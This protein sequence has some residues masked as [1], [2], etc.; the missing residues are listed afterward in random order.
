SS[1]PRAWSSRV[2][3]SACRSA[4]SD[5][6][7]SRSTGMRAP[8]A[9]PPGPTGRS[10]CD[11]RE[12]SM[13][14]QPLIAVRDVQASSQWYQRLLRCRSA[15]GGHEYEQLVEPGGACGNGVLLWFQVDDFDAAVSRAHALPAEVLDGPRVNPNA[16]HREIWVRDLDGYVVVLASRYGDVCPASPR[17]APPSA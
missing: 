9:W 11:E 4:R 17:G 14:P 5:R 16:N 8:R 1:R 12:S 13:K 7:S 3:A 15:H 10:I 6:P 2:D